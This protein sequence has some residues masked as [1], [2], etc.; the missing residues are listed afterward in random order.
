MR[1]IFLYSIL[2]FF[3]LHIVSCSTRTNASEER[4]K[5]IIVSILPQKFILESLV[6]S[7]YNIVVLMPPGANHTNFEPSP[8]LLVEIS[9]SDIL[10]TLGLFGYEELWQDKFLSIN[11]K[12]L[13]ASTSDNYPQLITETLQGGKQFTDP[14][15]WLSIS[16]IR[17]ISINMLDVLAEIYPEDKELF[18]KNFKIFDE[19]LINADSTIKRIIADSDIKGF[20][21]YHPSLS[22]YSAEYNLEQI[23]IE[24]EGKEATISDLNNVIESVR[25]KKLE[26]ILVSKQF[27]TKQAYVIAKQTNG[28]VF[29]F[30]PMEENVIDNLVHITTLITKDVTINMKNR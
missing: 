1:N 10:F 17:Q 3:L 4:S 12:L 30:N 15:I 2:L 19:K 11:Q 22:Y 27:D 25:S 6:D 18:A 16:G 26:N 28:N 24:K 9:K 5:Y 23:S 21:I 8:S 29:E 7:T 20:V 14:H 13:I